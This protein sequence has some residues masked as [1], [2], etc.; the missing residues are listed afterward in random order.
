MDPFEKLVEAKAHRLG[1][2]N[3][4]G[5]TTII[6]FGFVAYYIF[7]AHIINVIAV[8]GSPMFGNSSAEATDV[9][10]TMRQSIIVSVSAEVLTLLTIYAGIRIIRRRMTGVIIFH[11][12]SI[13]FIAALVYWAYHLAIHTSI[14]NDVRN[15][16]NDDDLSV[17]VLSMLRGT[18]IETMIFVAACI[19]VR[20]N[21]IL[22]RRDYRLEFH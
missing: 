17:D 21:F 5:Y 7:T 20:A 13:I 19:L 8:L 2:I 9:S 4:I 14:L 6:F 22:L 1:I 3:A 11:A 15:F 10:T 16:R 12:V 18:S